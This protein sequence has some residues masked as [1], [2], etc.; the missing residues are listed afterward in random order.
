[1]LKVVLFSLVFLPRGY[2]GPGGLHDNWAA[3]GCAGGAAGY[4]DR[5]LLGRSHV[6][7]HSDAL[8]VYGGDPTDPEGLLGK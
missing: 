3:G 5:L 6:Y 7:Q 1:M 8:R 4:I 2:L